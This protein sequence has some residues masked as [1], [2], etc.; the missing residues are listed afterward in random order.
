MR[1]AVVGSTGGWHASRLEAAL[2]ARGHTAAFV[3]VTRLVA[4]VAGG[5]RLRSGGEALER[6]DA[7]LVRGLPRGS[8]EQ[9]VFRVD[10]LRALGAGGVRVV[11][12]AR[13]IECTIDKLLASTLLERG[14]VP[15]PA[16]VACERADDALDAFSALGGDVVVKPL[17]G[18]MGFGLARVQ[19]ADIAR[20]VF[21][22]L[23]I[24]RAVYYLQATVDHGGRDLRALVVGPRVVAAIARSAPGWR[25]NLARGGTATPVALDDGQTALCLRAARLLGAE[26]AGVDLVRAADGRLLVLEVNSIPGWRGLEEATGADV[27][28]ALVGRLEELG[29]GG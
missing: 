14:G 7:V 24:E 25:T 13:A 26:Y 4:E 8:L 17:F 11:N 22:A 10:A 6:C 9:V 20:R 21:R 29:P 19:D 18:S 23:E 12:D 27:A 15:T 28:T 3:P 5:V 1:V 2:G 16:T